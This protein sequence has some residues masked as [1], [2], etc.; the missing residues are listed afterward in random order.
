MISKEK[1]PWNSTNEYSDV[2][3]SCTRLG[4]MFSSRKRDEN[5]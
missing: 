1:L 2:Q 5:Y 3:Y 4:Y